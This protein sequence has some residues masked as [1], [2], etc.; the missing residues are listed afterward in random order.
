MSGQEVNQD[1]GTSHEAT[2]DAGPSLEMKKNL[3]FFVQT[4]NIVL[5]CKDSYMVEPES[6][7]FLV[8]HGFDFNKQYSKGISYHHGLD[9]VGQCFWFLPLQAFQLH[10]HLYTL[11]FVSLFWGHVFFAFHNLGTFCRGKLLKLV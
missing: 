8:H 5:L 3:H 10:G 6:L 7:R 1:G 4:F 11:Y 9:K 2:Q